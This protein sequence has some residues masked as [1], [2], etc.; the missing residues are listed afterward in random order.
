MSLFCCPVCGASFV[1]E[2]R[3]LRCANGHCFDR[4]RQGYV[5]LLCTQTSSS[6]R[7]GDDRRMVQA[8]QQFLEGG[9]YAPLQQEVARIAAAVLPASGALLDA[10]CG[11][12][13]YTEAVYASA[14]QS[15]KSPSVAAVDISKDAAKAVARRLFPHECAVASV[16]SLPVEDHSFDL[17]LNLFSPCAFQEFWRV[18]RPGGLLLRVVPLRRHLYGLKAAI[19]DAPYENPEEET[20]LPGFSLV[21]RQELKWTLHLDT[22]AAIQ[23]L[24]EMTPYFYKTSAADQAKAA[25]LSV[26]DT[27]VEFGILLER[28]DGQK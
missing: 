16:F 13:Y 21:Q 25:A 11:E 3:T 1:E 17:V 10:G 12:G 24:F 15:G 7:H 2:N 18:L 8:R 19:Y 22:S 23:A 4:A 14:L 27:E 5:N 9:F 28:K 26:L 20:S 6:K